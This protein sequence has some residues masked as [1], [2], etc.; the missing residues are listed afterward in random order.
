MH[1]TYYKI[2][3]IDIPYA[4]E[5]VT[6][7]IEDE[8]VNKILYP[9]EVK[10]KDEEEV[11]VNALKDPID[12]PQFSEFITDGTLFIVNDATRPTPTSRV[13]ALMEK[14]LEEYDVEF[15]VATGSHREPTEEEFEWI[16]GD[17]Y[18]KRK[19]NIHFHDAKNDEMVNL[20]TTERGTDVKFNKM[21]SEAENVVAINTV[22]PHYFAGFTGGRKSFLPGVASY[23]TITQNHE[24]ALEEEARTLRLEGN[25]VHEDMMDA[26][27][28]FT[29]D[30]FALNMTLD[31]DGD[32]H[33][34]TAGDM[35]KSF[36]SEV[37]VAKR[38]FGVSIK[39]RSEIV[40]TAA[41]PIDVNLY[42]SHKALENG[43]LALA[44]GG[45]IILVSQCPEGIGPRNFYELMAS[46]DD[47]EEVLNKIE[48]EYKLGYHKAAKIVELCEDSSIWC[49]SELDENKT[50]KAF[51]QSKEDIQTA[52][53]EALSTTNGKATFLIEGGMVV[54]MIESE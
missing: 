21:V 19:K 49:V 23:E 18:E 5:K 54:P 40:V 32:I 34:A 6:V 9:N 8:R 30:V 3:Q 25:P 7:E 50:E 36:L 51:I 43:K 27:S 15:I 37:E 29:S 46:M 14:E 38:L 48:D 13:L 12:K 41:H 10:K 39:Q 16:F 20:G 4:G 33:N 31:R 17:I 53:D 24:F 44:E 47:P 45:I 52:L 28:K 2:M 1:E 26:F 42:Q 35:E 11:V 22:E